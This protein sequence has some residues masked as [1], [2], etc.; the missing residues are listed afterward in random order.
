MFDNIKKGLYFR[1]MQL[2]LKKGVDRYVIGIGL[3]DKCKN[4]S[5]F[6]T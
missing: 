4:Y 1:K 3:I 2:L 6:I 5:H